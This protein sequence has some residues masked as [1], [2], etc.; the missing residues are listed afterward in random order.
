V[1]DKRV[2]ESPPKAD[3]PLAEKNQS[4]KNKLQSI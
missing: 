3:P 4:V 1:A 2:K